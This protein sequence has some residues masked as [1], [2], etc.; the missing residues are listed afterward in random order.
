MNEQLKEVLQETWIN[1]KGRIFK[2]ELHSI[3]ISHPIL[4]SFRV[5]HSQMGRGYYE[6]Y[7]AHVCVYF[8]ASPCF[9]Y[10]V[11]RIPNH[12]EYFNMPKSREA[13]YVFYNALF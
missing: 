9:H 11:S 12:V 8:R 13:I 10:D 5:A 4:S 3:S 6:T 2:I 1:R 7:L